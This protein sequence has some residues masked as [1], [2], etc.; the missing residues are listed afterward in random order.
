MKITKTLF[1]STLILVSCSKDSGATRVE[2]S[3]DLQIDIIPDYQRGN[4]TLITSSPKNINNEIR[5]T[6][7]LPDKFNSTNPE[8]ADKIIWFP[9]PVRSHKDTLFGYQYLFSESKDTIVIASSHLDRDSESFDI[10]LLTRSS[11]DEKVK[12]KVNF[13]YKPFILNLNGIFNQNAL[14]TSNSIVL[15]KDSINKRSRTKKW[16]LAHEYYSN[17]IE[18]DPDST[19]SKISISYNI[20]N[21]MTFYKYAAIYGDNKRDSSNLKALE[22]MELN[23]TLRQGNFDSKKRQYDSVHIIILSLASGTFFIMFLIQIFKFWKRG[24]RK[25]SFSSSSIKNRSRENVRSKDIK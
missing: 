14:D 24:H 11:I 1:L 6:Y 25:K 9:L 8:T 21:N 23:K 18:L 20:P 15:F 10:G 3:Y 5:L 7:I 2:K 17:F 12:L 16:S 13:Y 22:S 4:V 19:M